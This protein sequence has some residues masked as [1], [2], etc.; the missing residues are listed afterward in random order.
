MSLEYVILTLLL[1]YIIEGGAVA[2]AAHLV[3]GK[4]MKGMELLTLAL[5]AAATFA[6]LDFFA[7]AVGSSARQGTG[8][9]IGAQQV[10]WPHVA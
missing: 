7:P 10:G 9:A 8:F 1:K 2:L 5:T 4:T 6:V 3:A